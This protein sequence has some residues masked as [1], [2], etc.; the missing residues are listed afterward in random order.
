MSEITEGTAVRIYHRELSGG[1]SL[2]V[3]QPGTYVIVRE[4]RHGDWVV[5]STEGGPTHDVFRKDVEPA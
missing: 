3:P 2:R 4:N 5:R 1:Q